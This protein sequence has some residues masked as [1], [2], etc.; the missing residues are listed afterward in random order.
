MKRSNKVRF[1]ICIPSFNRGKLAYKSVKHILKEL[2]MDCSILVLDNA[3]DNEVE[4]YNKIKKLSK[5]NQQLTYTKHAINNMTYGNYLSCFELAKSKYMM[6]ISDEDTLEISYIKYL[7]KQFKRNR[8]L[9]ILRGSIGSFKGALKMQS[10]TYKDVCYKRGKEALENHCFT[11]NYMSGTVYN[12][13]LI[14]KHKLLKYLQDN[15]LLN[16]AYPHIYF[17]L[18]ISV[19]CDVMRSSRISIYEG[20]MHVVTDNKGISGSLAI[21][22]FPYSFGSRLDQMIPLRNGLITA[23]TLMNGSDADFINLYM[24]LVI[25]YFYLISLPNAN[26]Y[27]ANHM[28]MDYLKKATLNFCYASIMAY[29]SLENYHND[30]VRL[31]DNIYEEYKEK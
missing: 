8:N 9:G 27:R 11:N 21:Y 20:E 12:L 13:K 15:L 6:W 7:L 28:H 18:L 5:K 25:K 4:Y 29:P 14:K 31:I 30:I 2:P 24:K 23:V 16:K 19:K 17:E 22:Q 26:L 10:D 1:T 3:S